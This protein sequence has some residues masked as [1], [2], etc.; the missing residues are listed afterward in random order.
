MRKIATA[1]VWIS[2]SS[3]TCCMFHIL[4]QV[5]ARKVPNKGHLYLIKTRSRDQ[6][7]EMFRPL[8]GKGK[9]A[10]YIKKELNSQG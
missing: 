7:N 6:C 5:G 2:K 1:T 8:M 9:I 10:I 4:P 3:F